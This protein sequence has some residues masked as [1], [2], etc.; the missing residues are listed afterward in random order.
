MTSDL[1]I[2]VIQC[3]PKGLCS[4]NYVIQGLG[5]HVEIKFNWISEI[6][7]IL[8]EGNELSI[9]KHGI[10]SGK[11]TLEVDGKLLA[12][13]KKRDA[14]S[15]TIDIADDSGAYVMEA[16][17]AFGRTFNLELDSQIFAVIKPDHALTRRAT[18]E[19]RSSQVEFTTLI[20]AFWLVVLMWKRAA[21]S[22]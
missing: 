14:F 16:V 12:S 5:R 9:I 15:R 19:V 22:S 17:S 3:L 7:A 2:P 18:I 10:T 13:A 8:I 11:W 20:F 4:W 21:N 1:T 6:G